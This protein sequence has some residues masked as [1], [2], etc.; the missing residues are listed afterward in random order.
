MDNKHKVARD[1]QSILTKVMKE[2]DV[3]FY[4]VT[5]DTVSLS[6]TSKTSTAPA[7]VN[8]RSPVI[9]TQD[10]LCSLLSLSLIVLFVAL[11]CHT[12]VV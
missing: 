6:C 3:I 11:R 7:G 9:S 2:L 4:G 8:F 10:R 1:L 5:H 12:A